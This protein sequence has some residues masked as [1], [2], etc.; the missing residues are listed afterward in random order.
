MAATTSVS[1]VFVYM[2]VPAP[3]AVLHGVRDS[4]SGFGP[5]LGNGI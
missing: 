2:S 1:Y 5:E 3:W 4:D